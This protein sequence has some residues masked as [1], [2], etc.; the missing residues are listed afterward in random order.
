[1][2]RNQSL[3]A[4]ALD[5]V[6]RVSV[7]TTFRSK[8]AFAVCAVAATVL[9]G[10]TSPALAAGAQIPHDQVVGFPTRA[11][12]WLYVY[13][14]K[15]KV[16][17]G[18]VPFPAVDSFGRWSGGV[19]STG[20]ENGGCSKNLGQVYVRYTAV[21]GGRGCAVMYSWYFPKDGN[22]NAG[23]RHDWEEIVVWLT[24]CSAKADPIAVAYSGH[25][26][27]ILEY[28]ASGGIDLHTAD[29]KIQPKVVYKSDGRNFAL[30]TVRDEGGEQP[31][32]QWGYLTPAARDTLSTANF[33]KASPKFIDKNF[34]PK[35]N[36]AKYW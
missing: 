9:G 33:G 23:H 27:Y 26:D 2:K 12:P 10:T 14:P 36:E 1:M 34:L 28:Q 21:P 3:I 32:I 18:C 4:T 19:K 7:F 13:Q 35:V 31:L 8:S 16:I 20:L 30:E 29:G 24:S 15:L 6:N 17:D 5:A 22:S 11:E 25:G